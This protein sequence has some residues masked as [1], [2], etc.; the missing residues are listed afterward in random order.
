M[1]TYYHNEL[2]QRMDPGE[3]SLF[4]KIVFTSIYSLIGQGQAT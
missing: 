3:R 2:V 1:V 4:T